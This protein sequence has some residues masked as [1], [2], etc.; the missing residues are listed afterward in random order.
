[1]WGR[2]VRQ[3]TVGKTSTF[4]LNWGGGKGFLYGY[5][6]VG[7]TPCSSDMTSLGEV[8]EGGRDV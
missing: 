7:S 4:L 2:K 6:P 5:V 8:G 1:M 3:T